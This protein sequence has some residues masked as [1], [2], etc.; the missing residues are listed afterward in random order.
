[1]SS[2]DS[3]PD[4]E[5]VQEPPAVPEVPEGSVEI[6]LEDLTILPLK[7]GD[8]LLLRLPG[9]V[10]R[11]AAAGVRE[12]VMRHVPGHEV[13]VIDKDIE[14]AV[15]RPPQIKVMCGAS[16]EG[17]AGTLRCVLEEG[18]PGGIPERH[19][20]GE[21]GTYFTLLGQAPAAP[22]AATGEAING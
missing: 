10:T 11:P 4:Y 2:E 6:R 22:C 18:H 21:P 7:P 14:L 17:L 1:M 16:L 15:V 5:G 20:I 3:I 13:L 12:Y 19:E 8:I 9:R